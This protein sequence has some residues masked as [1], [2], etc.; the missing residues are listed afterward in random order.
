MN[1]RLIYDFPHKLQL[2]S[3]PSAPLLPSTGLLDLVGR[4]RLLLPQCIWCALPQAAPLTLCGHDPCKLLRAKMHSSQPFPRQPQG[5]LRLRA[6]HS[7]RPS[8]RCTTWGHKRLAC[9]ARLPK[10]EGP[11]QEDASWCMSVAQVLSILRVSPLSTLGLVVLH[12][13]LGRPVPCA[14]S[15]HSRPCSPLATSGQCRISSLLDTQPAGSAEPEAHKKQKKRAI[16]PPLSPLRRTPSCR[17]GQ[18]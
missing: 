15:V 5:D 11:G 12:C 6:W 14:A 13:A 4:L 7:R 10:L 9:R 16:R 17:N 3:A 2:S 18:W 1:G 8:H